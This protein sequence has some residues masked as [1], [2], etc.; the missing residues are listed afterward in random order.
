MLKAN[1]HYVI[2][3]VIQFAKKRRG[4]FL[5]ATNEKSPLAAA[6][7]R[8]LHWFVR[9]RFFLAVLHLYP[10]NPRHQ[11]SPFSLVRLYL[12]GDGCTVVFRA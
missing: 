11:I 1:L 9:V 6:C 10:S 2:M 12:A 5:P 7:T 8:F 3:I 4:G